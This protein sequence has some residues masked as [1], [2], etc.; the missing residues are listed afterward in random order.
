MESLTRTNDHS[1]LMDIDQTLCNLQE[2]SVVDYMDTPSYSKHLMK[3]L[4]VNLVAIR[5]VDEDGNAHIHTYTDDEAGV[6]C[7]KDKVSPAA[8]QYLLLISEPRR[9]SM[10]VQNGPFWRGGIP[11]GGKKSEGNSTSKNS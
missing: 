2:L 6:L 11:I 9:L 1:R 8:F 4:D 5:K 10:M 7:D 3:L